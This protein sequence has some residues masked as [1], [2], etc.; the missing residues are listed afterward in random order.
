MH[1][2]PHNHNYCVFHLDRTI[3]FVGHHI[4]TLTVALDNIE[5]SY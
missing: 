2:Q 4:I 5:A 1:F 3:F